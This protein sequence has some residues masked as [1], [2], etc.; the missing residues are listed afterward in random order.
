MLVMP[1]VRK[2]AQQ[3]YRMLRT[4]TLAKQNRVSL[5]AMSG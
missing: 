4:G 5:N 2:G 1:Y 3:R